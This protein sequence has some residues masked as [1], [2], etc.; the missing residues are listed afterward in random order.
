M[1]T[2]FFSNKQQMEVKLPLCPVPGPSRNCRSTVSNEAG[3]AVACFARK[4]PKYYS[5]TTIRSLGWWG[6]TKQKKWEKVLSWTTIRSLGWWGTSWFLVFLLGW[7]LNHHQTRSLFIHEPLCVIC[8]FGFPGRFCFINHYFS[9]GQSGDWF[10]SWL[11]TQ[12]WENGFKWLI[13][14]D[15]PNKLN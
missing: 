3:R 13:W 14:I 12:S 10:T 11:M 5:W 2:I 9:F 1:D 8:R 15:C 4:P 7:Q 6:T